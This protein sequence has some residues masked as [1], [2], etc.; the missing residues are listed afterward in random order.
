MDRPDPL[1]ADSHIHITEPGSGYPDIG[2]AGILMGCTSRAS[3]WTAMSG[4]EGVVRFYG[5]HPWYADGWDGSVSERLRSIL[6]SD[7]E[8]NVGEIGLDSKRGDVIDQRPAFEE[9]ISLASEF[10]RTANIHM[11]GCEKDVLDVVRRRGAGCRS[12]ILHSFSSESY[13]KPFADAGCMFS[14]NPRIL[15]RS[16][17]RL[18]RLF[19]SIPEERLLL[20]SDS[21]YTPPG[22]TGMA[23]FAYA[24]GTR[25]GADPGQLMSLSLDNAR[26][27]IR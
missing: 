20:E 4:T 11:V 27:C 22:F 5:V 17:R 10:G 16:D 6:S 12:V 1:F 23:G 18:I 9:Q 14:L 7:W 3:E 13:V 25:V 2:D 15:A 26:R 19:S 8:A 21:P 24:L